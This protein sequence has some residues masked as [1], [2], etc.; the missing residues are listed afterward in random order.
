MEA[1]A[2]KRV[3]AFELKK[4][5]EQRGITKSEMAK[6]MRT[7]R[8]ALNRILDPKNESA[9]LN[10][11]TKAFA[12]VQKEIRFTIKNKINTEGSGRSATNQAE[13]CAR[14]ARKLSDISQF[15]SSIEVKSEFCW[16]N[17]LELKLS[18]LKPLNLVLEKCG[19]ERF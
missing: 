16:K 5:M 10:S 7:S 3:I 12:V 2:L 8:A 17:L 13:K 1:N 19:E 9:T 6:M 18:A 11:I 15:P 14:I 4:A